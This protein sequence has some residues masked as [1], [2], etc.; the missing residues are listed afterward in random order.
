MLALDEYASFFRPRGEVRLGKGGR[1]N[2]ETFLNL[3]PD[4]TYIRHDPDDWSTRR[5]PPSAGEMPRTLA[6][7]SILLVLLRHAD[8]IKIGCAT[9]G[10]NSLCRS[11]REHVWR[12]ALY[13]PHMDMHRVAGGVSLACKTVCGRYDVPGYAIDDMN[14]YGGFEG[15]ETI[16]AAAAFSPE[17]GELTVFVLNA[18]LDEDQLLTLNLKGFDRLSFSEHTELYSDDP[19]ACNTFENPDA[20]CPRKNTDTA[21]DRGILT[22]KLHKASWNV[23]R[24]MV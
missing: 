15:V 2:A 14:Q 13:Y 20:I 5:M 6:E 18:D 21:L 16:Q 24:F 19:E 10:L 23:F 8:R 22:A 17:T 7:A 1:Q 12:G 3:D 11:S 9:G 4:R